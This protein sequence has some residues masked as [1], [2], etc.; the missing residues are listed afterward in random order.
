MPSAPAGSEDKALEEAGG[1]T[2]LGK[3]KASPL[4]KGMLPC[5]SCPWRVDADVSAI[6]GFNRVKA[7]GLLRT[8]SLGEGDAFRPIMGCHHSKDNHDY[9]CKGYLARE[10]WSNLNVR[11]LLAKDDIEN[12]SA[13]LHACETHGVLLEPDYPAVLRKLEGQ[14]DG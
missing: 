5:K 13:V 4:A 6:P 1:M 12:P 2:E 14:A 9:A 11:V 8:A 3:K 7:V 10:G